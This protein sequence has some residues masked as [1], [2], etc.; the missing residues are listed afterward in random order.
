[1]HRLWSCFQCECRAM[2][3]WW[4]TGGDFWL[5]FTTDV[6]IWFY[7]VQCHHICWIFVCKDYPGCSSV[8][9]KEHQQRQLHL[10]MTPDYAYITFTATFKATRLLYKKW[11][12]AWQNTTFWFYI[13]D[14]NV[15][16]RIRNQGNQLW[17][18]KLSELRIVLNYCCNPRR[19]NSI[20][21]PPQ[22][23]LSGSTKIKN[24]F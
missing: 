17:G 4:K 13:I 6:Q 18:N 5:V 1:M 3:T 22:R 24:I 8:R 14:S 9:H 11:N 21:V 7:E 15:K 12:F 16:K 10:T 19:L 23:E 2:M 20:T